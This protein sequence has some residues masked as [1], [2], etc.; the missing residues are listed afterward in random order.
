MN[1]LHIDTTGDEAKVS[2]AAGDKKLERVQ[3]AKGKTASI[4][5]P[6]IKE[7]IDEADIGIS[8]IEKIEVER[9]PG[10]WNGTRIGVVTAKMLAWSLGLSEPALDLTPLYPEGHEESL[11]INY[12]KAQK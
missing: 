4:L 2:L 1:I 7:L 11:K 12:E 6:M 10:S 9:G 5:V 3:E 8:E